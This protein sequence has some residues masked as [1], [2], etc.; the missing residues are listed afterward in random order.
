VDK[1]LREKMAMNGRRFVENN[2]DIEKIT[3]Q[4]EEIIKTCWIGQP[5]QAA[6]R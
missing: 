2:F 6:D 1:S 3:G 4:F 5:N